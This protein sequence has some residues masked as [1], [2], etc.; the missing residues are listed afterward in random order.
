IFGNY[1]RDGDHVLD[2]HA[3]TPF[4]MQHSMS[5]AYNGGRNR[6]FL[7]QRSTHTTV[8]Y[9]DTSDA[10]TPEMANGWTLALAAR[11]LDA[12]LIALGGN[13]LS[14]FRHLPELYIANDFG[15]DRLLLNR[16]TPGR[17]RFEIVEGRRTLSTPRSKVL[18]Q[19]SFKGMGVDFGDV[20]GDGHSA[21]A[22]SNI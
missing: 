7:W 15:P 12:D 19:D 11:D 2:S 5:R 17:P 8:S 10:F 3:A 14:P 1:F 9:R 22:V 16:S 21:I 6:L 4:E 20:V 18:G 13:K